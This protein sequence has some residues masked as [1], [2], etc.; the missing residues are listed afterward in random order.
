MSVLIII[1]EGACTAADAEAL[2]V[3]RRRAKAGGPEADSLHAQ[4]EEAELATAVAAR[5]AHAA[6]AEAAALQQRVAA[7][8]KR[9]EELS[10][11]VRGSR[12]PG[13]L[14]NVMP[15]CL[16]GRASNAR[17]VRRLGED[18]R[19]ARRMQHSACMRGVH[20]QRC[21]CSG[22]QVRMVAEPQRVGGAKGAGGG[23]V[24]GV[25]DMFG[26]GAGFTR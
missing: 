3:S 25:L 1:R 21:A 12:S 8:E 23:R 11:Q 13:C 10:W 7:A 14:S 19:T 16:L 18:V 4:L 24:S 15:S 22:R 26:C 9:A 17:T 6:E 2:A 5:R 20:A